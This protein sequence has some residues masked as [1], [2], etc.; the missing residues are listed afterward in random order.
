MK[1]VIYSLSL[2]LLV[3][4]FSCCITLFS[5][6]DVTF[7]IRETHLGRKQTGNINSQQT[8]SHIVVVYLCG[9]PDLES[10]VGDGA[11]RVDACGLS[12]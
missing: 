11:A 1:Y 7:E 2:P 3:K 8:I 10:G 4:K 9:A 6:L 5:V 12:D